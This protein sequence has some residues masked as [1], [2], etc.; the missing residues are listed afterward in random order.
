MCFAFSQTSRF[1]TEHFS[2]PLG[3][4]DPIVHCCSHGTLPPASVLKALTLS[5]LLLTTKI[6]T[7]WRLQL[8]H[9]RHLSTHATATLYSL[10]RK[11]PRGKA[12]P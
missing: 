9:A 3:P 2:D 6:C 7:G 8:A 11:P 4:T 12:L 5:I 1:G 10:R